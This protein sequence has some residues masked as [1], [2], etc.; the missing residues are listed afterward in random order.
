METG[1]LTAAVAALDLL[2]FL[3]LPEKDYHITPALSLSKFY[4]NSLLV[5]FNSRLHIPGSRGVDSESSRN[6]NVGLGGVT[7]RGGSSN[8]PQRGG[9]RL[10]VENSIW[11]DPMP[12]EEIRVRSI[13]TKFY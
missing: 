5:I 7:S 6:V 11:V 4:S 10:D 3:L 1:S 12:L 2:L 13:C 9:I 8:Q